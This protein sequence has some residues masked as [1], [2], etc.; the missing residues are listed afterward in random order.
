MRGILQ[1]LITISVMAIAGG[2]AW[3]LVQLGKEALGLS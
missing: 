2:W 1:F 3:L